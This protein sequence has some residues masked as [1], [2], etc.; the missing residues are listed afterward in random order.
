MKRSVITVC[1]LRRKDLTR[2]AFRSV[3]EERVERLSPF[4]VS[5]EE[6]W[7]GN[8]AAAQRVCCITVKRIKEK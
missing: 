6:V 2:L 8:T 1:K 4:N 3:E 7:A 5:K